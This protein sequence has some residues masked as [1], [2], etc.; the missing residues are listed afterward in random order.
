MACPV[1]VVVGDVVVEEGEGEG[2]GHLS[3]S[4]ETAGW[5]RRQSPGFCTHHL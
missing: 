4:L 1:L 2:E 3:L 5:E